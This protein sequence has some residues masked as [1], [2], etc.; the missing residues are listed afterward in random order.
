MPGAWPSL[1]TRSAPTAKDNVPSPANVGEPPA[2]W[3]KLL[4]GIG[5]P[6]PAIDPFVKDIVTALLGSPLAEKAAAAGVPDIDVP[7]KVDIELSGAIVM[8]SAEVVLMI[9]KLSGAVCE[10]ATV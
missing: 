6:A 3:A 10:T 4:M 8:V 5:V 2:L 1:M 7:F 9:P